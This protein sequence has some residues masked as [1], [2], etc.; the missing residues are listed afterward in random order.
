MNADFPDGNAQLDRLVL[1]ELQNVQ[2]IGITELT[3][4]P[5][6]DQRSGEED[7]VPAGDPAA[8]A[9]VDVPPTLRRSLVEA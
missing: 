5:D 9:F 6:Q 4:D 7:A 2:R 8:A 1:P 3:G